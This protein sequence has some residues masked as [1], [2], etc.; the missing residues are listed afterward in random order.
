MPNLLSDFTN[1][2]V[3]GSEPTLLSL[4]RG[5]RL[6]RDGIKTSSKAFWIRILRT[7]FHQNIEVFSLLFLKGKVS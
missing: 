1:P 3:I 2:C 7:P 6:I 4:W 5:K